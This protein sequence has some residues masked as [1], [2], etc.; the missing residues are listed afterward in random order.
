MKPTRVTT[1]LDAQAT[2]ELRDL[3][4]HLLDNPSTAPMLRGYSG[5]IARGQ[6]VRWAISQAWNQMQAKQA[7]VPRG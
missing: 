2:R 6:I 5:K 1:H 3:Q 4:R 7:E